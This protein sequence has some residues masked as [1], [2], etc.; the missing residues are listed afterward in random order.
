MKTVPSRLPP[1]Y[2]GENKSA[3]IYRMLK[4]SIL[5]GQLKAGIRLPPERDYAQILGVARGTVNAAYNR[6]RD[7]GY[8]QSRT[9]DGT[10]VSTVTLPAAGKG[11]ESSGK[12]G[13]LSRRG[14]GLSSYLPEWG[15][16]PPDRSLPFRL[17][18]PAAEL[19]PF[20]RWH[21]LLRDM[22]DPVAHR[23]ADYHGSS[24]YV[25]L[26][27]ALAEVVFLSR[28]I[29]CGAEDL[30]VTNG[31][32]QGL[33]M[34]FT[35]LCDAGDRVAIEDPCYPG[36]VAAMKAAGLVPVPIPVDAEGLRVDALERLQG[37]RAVVVSP[38]HQFPLGYQLKLNRR[39]ALLAWA[40]QNDAW[41]VED[42]YDGEFQYN[43]NAVPSLKNLDS[44]HRVAYVGSFS[45]TLFPSIRLGFVV[46]SPAVVKGLGRAKAIADRFSSIEAQWCLYKFIE[47]GDYLR[48]LRRMRNV[49]S[50]RRASFVEHAST[51]F[52]ESAFADL[53]N[54]GLHI[55]VSLDSEIDDIAICEAAAT[56]GIDIA[57]ISAY[58]ITAKRKG[59]LFGFAGFAEKDA[60]SALRLFKPVWR[61]LTAGVTRG[62]AHA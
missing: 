48:H 33:S 20:R 14:A 38:T 27:E 46:A 19:F 37:I 7:E 17:G 41:I 6:L 1:A 25:R 50:R 16:A 51:I 47:S 32:Q 24:G 42:D 11:R 44:E 58:C 60:S 22:P 61:R 12:T 31:A 52:G 30:I 34:L 39:L 40:Q 18:Q 9:G 2:E 23:L 49:Y 10:Y 26:R 53:P 54:A 43:F 4:E 56:H 36:S 59:L 3:L 21:G 45:K 5:T 28:G 29:N 15:N 62:I 8:V 57:P 35:V 55:C 13:Q